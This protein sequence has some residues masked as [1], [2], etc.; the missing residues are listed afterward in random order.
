MEVPGGFYFV[1]EHKTGEYYKDT[2]KERM[3]PNGQ[4]IVEEMDL[5]MILSKSKLSIS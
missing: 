1:I 3:V 4:A 2:G 5:M